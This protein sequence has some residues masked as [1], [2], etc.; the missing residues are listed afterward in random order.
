LIDSDKRFS[1]YNV[2][3]LP[4]PVSKI[5]QGKIWTGILYL[6]FGNGLI[7]GLTTISGVI[8]SSQY[9]FWRGITAGIVLT[10]TWS[11]QIPFGLFLASRFNSVVTFLGILFLNILCSGQT[12]AGGDFWYLPFAIPPRMM[13]PIIG[14]NPNGIPLEA[15]SPLHDTAVIFPGLIITV[16]LLFIG[17]FITT[18]WFSDRG[19][20][21]ESA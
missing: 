8:F 14:I 16:S 18:K 12:I 10:L 15:G 5:W 6:A 21:H 4:F 13:A 19:R 20:Y 2:N 9:P 17:Y 11:W 7:F 3:I 1:F